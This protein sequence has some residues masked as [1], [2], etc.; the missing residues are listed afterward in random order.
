MNSLYENDNQAWTSAS[1]SLEIG[2]EEIHLWRVRLDGVGYQD[3]RLA[4]VLS[5]EEQDRAQRFRFDQ[6]RNRFIRSHGISRLILAKYTSVDPSELTFDTGTHGKPFLV[7]VYHPL[8]RFNLSHSGDLMIL[9]LAVAR[10]IGVDVEV[11]NDQVEWKQIAANYFNE[12]ELKGIDSIPAGKQQLQAFYRVW[13]IKEAYLKARGDGLPGGLD[14]VVVN[15]EPSHPEIFISLPGGEIEKR[16]WQAITFSPATGACG[17]VVAQ[18]SQLPY[19]L[20]QY[21]WSA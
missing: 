19:K 12:Y 4:A 6:H 2:S 11:I 15:L 1:T 13:T 3:E 10:E 8:L 7:S 5:G 14:R 17:A 16:R 21:N 20:I 18:R 9:G